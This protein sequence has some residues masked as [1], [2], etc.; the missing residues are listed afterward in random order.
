MRR[1]KV[2]DLLKFVTDRVT[3]E[4]AI[5]VSSTKQGRIEKVIQDEKGFAYVVRRKGKTEIVLD[6]WVTP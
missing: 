6:T 1:Y 4:G 2:G 5:V 3:T